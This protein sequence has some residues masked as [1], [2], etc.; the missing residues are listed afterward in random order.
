MAERNIRTIT[1]LAHRL[2]EHGVEISTQ[3]LTRVV[4]DI[5]ARLSMD[6][7]AGLTEVLN[8]GVGDIIMVA[9]G[10]DGQPKASGGDNDE[11]PPRPPRKRRPAHSAPRAGVDDKDDGLSLTGPVV[12][13]FLL[14][15]PRT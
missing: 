5:P 12:R 3:Q 4:N 9:P 2:A 14:P 6:L 1:D 11:V 15:E 8:C 7:L 10:P 13:P